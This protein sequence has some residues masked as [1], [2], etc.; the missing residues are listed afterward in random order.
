MKLDYE[1]KIQELKADYDDKI[2]KLMER[3]IALEQK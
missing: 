3:I 1:T 2:S